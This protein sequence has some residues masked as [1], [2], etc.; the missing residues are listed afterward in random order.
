MHYNSCHGALYGRLIWG[1]SKCGKGTSLL[2][3]YQCSS[4]QLQLQKEF[5]IFFNCPALCL[6]LHLPLLCQTVL[7]LTHLFWKS[8]TADNQL[9]EFHKD[10]QSK[11]IIR[12]FHVTTHRPELEGVTSNSSCRDGSVLL[13]LRVTTSYT[14]R[15][16]G[17]DCTDQRDCSG[18]HDGYQQQI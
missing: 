3:I 8:F 13:W 14:A 6:P 2:I 15:S 4:H 1:D 7:P 17:T 11:H 12:T 9:I 10:L 16:S 5:K 18:K